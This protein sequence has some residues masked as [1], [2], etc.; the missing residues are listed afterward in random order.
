MSTTWCV[1][2]LKQLS[3]T[4]Y[5]HNYVWRHEAYNLQLPNIKVGHYTLCMCPSGTDTH[6]WQMFQSSS[7]KVF[8]KITISGSHYRICVCIPEML[9]TGRLNSTLQKWLCHCYFSLP[10]RYRAGAR[11]R[12]QRRWVVLVYTPRRITTPRRN[13]STSPFVASGL[14]CWRP[15]IMTNGL[16]RL[17]RVYFIIDPGKTLNFNNAYFMA[18]GFL[19][20]TGYLHMSGVADQIDISWRAPHRMYRNTSMHSRLQY[21]WHYPSIFVDMPCDSTTPIEPESAP[22]GNPEWDRAA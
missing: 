22:P 4:A 21:P 20:W 17:W 18:R 8:H 14:G 12:Q 5:H 2:A 7:G 6:R 15:Y 3:A 10:V 11:G 13:T 1:V 9:T 19:S 16:H